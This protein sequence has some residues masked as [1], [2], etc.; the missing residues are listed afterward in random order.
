MNKPR[1]YAA[2]PIGH[3][4]YEQATAWRNEAKRILSEVGIAV[5]SPMRAKEFL[6]KL[7]VM[8]SRPDVYDHPLATSKGIMARDHADCVRADVV[9]VNFLGADRVSLGTAMELAWCF[10]HHIPV[11]CVA[12]PTNINVA[13]PMAAEAIDYLVPTLAEAIEIVKTICL[14][15]YKESN[16]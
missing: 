2:G 16:G 3:C 11:V 8:P 14:P 1:V 15:D 7:S 13:H 10:E 5:Y 4:S 6:D 12:E 9:L